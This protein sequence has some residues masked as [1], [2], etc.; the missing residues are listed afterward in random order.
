MKFLKCLP[1]R[2]E[3]TVKALAGYSLDASVQGE[4]EYTPGADQEH[5]PSW[6]RARFFLNF[7]G[8]DSGASIF[9]FGGGRNSAPGSRMPV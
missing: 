7:P 9:V 4:V 6:S 5:F 2:E 3:L 8:P 1:G